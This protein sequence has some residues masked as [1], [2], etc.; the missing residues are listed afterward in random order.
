[1]QELSDYQRRI[2]S[3]NPNVE[4]LTEK[5]VVYTSKFKIS[6]VEKYLNGKTA[7]EV[8]ED[9]QINP[10]FFIPDY[11]H[12]CIKRWKKKYL[13]EGKAS[14]KN[15]QTGKKST[16]RPKKVN[17]DEMTVAE[18]KALI[19]VQQEVIEMLKKNRALAKK[20]KEK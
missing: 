12:S 20:K 3:K 4:K 13:E 7:N 8:F 14:L 10:K 17:T 9:A 11:C 5:H 16:G 1:M 19:E 2:L 15:S 6:A 18:M